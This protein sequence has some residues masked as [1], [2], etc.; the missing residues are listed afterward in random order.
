M[1]DYNNDDELIIIPSKN[2]RSR[3][4]CI[5]EQDNIIDDIDI[6]FKISKKSENDLYNKKRED[7]LFKLLSKNYDNELFQNNSKWDILNSELFKNINKITN[8]NIFKVIKK[9]GRR[10]NYDLLLEYDSKTI[11]LEF[12]FNCKKITN[13]PQFANIYCHYFTDINYC[14]YFYD[15]FLKDICEIYNLP[16]IEK[17]KYIKSIYNVNYNCDPFFLSLYNFDKI[18]DDKF[19]KKEII[20]KNS[21]KNFLNLCQFN[22]DDINKKILE[23]KD[24]IFLLWDLKT[25]KFYIECFNIDDIRIF[26]F[27]EIKN[28][29]TLVFNTF[30]NKEIHMLL[31]WKNHKGVLNPCWQISIRNK[32]ININKK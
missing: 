22:I 21:I 24:K 27:K 5:D 3:L 9:G 11:F 30:S 12:K 8:N 14:E 31:R 2:K 6:F 16:I 1:D 15:N 32:K 29:N 10:L 20:V 17:N 19:M 4:L 18:K 26:N 23:Q 7:I 13:I 28:N 25:Q